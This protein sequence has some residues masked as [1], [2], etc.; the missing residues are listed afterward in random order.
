MRRL[1]L[2]EAELVTSRSLPNGDRPLFFNASTQTTQEISPE[3]ES[4][5]IVTP[6]EV[7]SEVSSFLQTLADNDP[8]QVEL[9]NQLMFEFLDEEMSDS[10]E[11]QRNLEDITEY[12]DQVRASFSSSLEGFEDLAEVAL[13]QETLTA[14]MG[15]IVSVRDRHKLN[16]AVLSVLRRRLD[17]GRTQNLTQEIRS[18][19]RTLVEYE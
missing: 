10:I 3:F 4:Y 18:W 1:T 14:S 12:Y 7:R 5:L 16:Y 9:R 17:N 11:R 8:N 13:L 15:E 2:E 6:L 19:I